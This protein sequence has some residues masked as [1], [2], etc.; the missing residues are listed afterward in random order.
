MLA[1]SAMVGRREACMQLEILTTAAIFTTLRAEWLRLLSQAILSK[2][3]LYTT[4]A[5][6]L[7][8]ALWRR[9]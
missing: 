9:A 7:V 2:R 6:N 5:G 8:A 3:V 4:V 1:E